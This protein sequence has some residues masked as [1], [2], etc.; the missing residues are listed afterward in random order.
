MGFF[1]FFKK[2]RIDEDK[3]IEEAVNKIAIESFGIREPTPEELKE[4]EERKRL[5]EEGRQIRK[6]KIAENGVDV[7]IFTNNKILNDAISFLDK[8]APSYKY[9]SVNMFNSNINGD[10]KNLT[11]TG[12]LP[13]NV[14]E[15]SI[16]ADSFYTDFES[17]DK[18]DSVIVHLKYLA[19][20]TVNMVDLHL[21]H[22]K[23]RHGMSIRTIDNEYRITSITTTDILRDIQETLYLEKKPQETETSIELF[24]SVMKNNL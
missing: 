8:F 2:K 17:P 10:F 7:N 22:K 13:K 6:E 15:A 5:S 21:W 1:D 14:F 24:D 23:K 20:G 12:K 11:K 9:L 3:L 4:E 16:I 19:D 18:D